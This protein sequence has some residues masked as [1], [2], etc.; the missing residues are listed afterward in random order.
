MKR[1]S[2]RITVGAIRKAVR[3]A[4]KGVGVVNTAVI[5]LY[6]D[7]KILEATR[8]L[9]PL[10]EILTGVCYIDWSRIN[11]SIIDFGVMK[12]LPPQRNCMAELDEWIGRHLHS[13]AD[14]FW[15]APYSDEEDW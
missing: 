14:R 11:V 13:L 10:L 8:R 3:K 9:T 6:C 15:I 2:G 1:T 4:K 7:P 12:M 5:P